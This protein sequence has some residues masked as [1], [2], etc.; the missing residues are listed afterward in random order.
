MISNFGALNCVKDLAPLGALA[1]RY[2]RPG[3]VVMLGLMAR[4]CALEVLYFL[5]TRRPD[6]AGRRRGEGPVAVSIYPWE[7]A[8]SPAGTERDGSAQNHLAVRVVSVTAVGNR[9]RAGLTAPQ[10]LTAELSDASAHELDL[11]PGAPV[12]ATWKA[13]ATRLLRL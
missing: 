8:L 11:A 4:T 2:V 13:A 12:I 3:G 5:A 10:P 1:K 7:I 9:I 6:L